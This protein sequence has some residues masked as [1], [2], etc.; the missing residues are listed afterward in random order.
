MS[1]NIYAKYVRDIKTLKG[2]SQEVLVPPLGMRSQGMPLVPIDIARQVQGYSTWR[3]AVLDCWHPQEKSMLVSTRLGNMTEVHTVAYPGDMP[4]RLTPGGGTVYGASYCPRDGKYVLFLRDN[5]GDEAFQIYR[6]DIDS[7]SLSR[8]TEYGGAKNFGFVWSN[9]GDRI[10]YLSS[11]YGG[12]SIDIFV[13][14]PLDP[15]RSDRLLV[16]AR[17]AAFSVLAWSADD[18]Q[19]LLCERRSTAEIYLWLADVPSGELTRL[20]GYNKSEKIAYRRGQFSRDGK[21]IYLTCDREHSQFQ[22]LAYMDLATMDCEY[23]TEDLQ[24]DVS[25]FVLSPNGETIAYVVN[26]NG[27]SQLRLIDTRSKMDHAVPL[28]VQGV[29]GGL[30]WHNNSCDLGFQLETYCSP[31]DVYSLNIGT[32]VLRRWT[33]SKAGDESVVEALKSL[34]KPEL[35]TWKSFDGLTISGLLY[36]PP[37]KFAGKRPVII[38]IHGGP[39]SQ[40]KPGFLKEEAY[41]LNELG[42]AILKPNIRGSKG[43]GKTFCRL[44]DGRLRAD[45]YRDIDTLIDWIG[46]RVDLDSDRILVTGKSYGGHVA[47]TVAAI[48]GD[49]IRCAINE[50]GMSNLVTFLEN[51]EKSRRALRRREYGD[52]RDPETRAFLDWLSPLK[53][54]DFINKPLL[55]I[56]GRNDRRVPISEAEQMVA[57]LKARDVPVWSLFAEDEGHRFQKKLNLRY[58]FLAKVLFIRRYLL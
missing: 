16:E 38:S 41:I 27:Y 3:T 51:T 19:L 46:T 34:P 52:E 8:L 40:A 50:C 24:A 23:L 53:N 26:E 6:F 18:S 17:G 37:Q 35:I 45:A 48:Y 11:R 1:E 42:V 49:R 22:R 33:Y 29:I 4:E 31:A 25:E 15:Q 21:G 58:C 13:M 56:H 30:T 28:P 57:A 32:K 14:D 12:E 47:L 36:M 7:G 39:A 44:D 5:D 43:F 20:T 2:V 54:V 9:G 55:V 10:A